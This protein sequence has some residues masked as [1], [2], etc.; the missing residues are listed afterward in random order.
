MRLNDDIERTTRV[1]FHG[2]SI[3]NAEGT[4]KATEMHRQLI[5]LKG[6]FFCF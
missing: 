3:S 6:K 1:S 5:K 4:T 2:G